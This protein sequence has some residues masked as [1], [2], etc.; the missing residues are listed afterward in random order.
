MGRFGVRANAIALGGATRMV[1][2]T[3][4]SIQVTEAD[5]VADDEF[6][7]LNPGNSAPD[8]GV[9]GVGRGP[10]RHRSGV[11]SRGRLHHPLRAVAAGHRDQAVEGPR[12]W[13]PAE[14][15]DAVN[16]NIFRCRPGGLNMG[17]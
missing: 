11:P 16:A 1:A 12:R 10:A 8:G 6:S 15:G 14:I 4:P 7:R 3:I 5:Q 2:A 13:Q 17:G 9:A